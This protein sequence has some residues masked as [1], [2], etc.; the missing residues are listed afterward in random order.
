MHVTNTSKPCTGLY[1]GQSR[2]H[3]EVG[4]ANSTNMLGLWH[5]LA[6]FHVSLALRLARFMALELEFCSE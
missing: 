5:M 3:T 6:L 2:P 4:R 1:H